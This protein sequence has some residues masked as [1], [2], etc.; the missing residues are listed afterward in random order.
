MTHKFKAGRCIDC[1]ERDPV[2][3]NP[4]PGLLLTRDQERQF[5]RD[6]LTYHVQIGDGST[7][8]SPAQNRK[9]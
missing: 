6:D 3:S 2:S 5:R 1:G 4:R 9:P 8:C 7:P